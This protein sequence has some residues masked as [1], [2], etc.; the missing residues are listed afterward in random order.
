M[1]A[2]TNGPHLDHVDQSTLNMK[3]VQ[4]G[5]TSTDT[6]STYLSDVSNTADMEPSPTDHLSGNQPILMSQPRIKIPALPKILNTIL[7]PRV[8]CIALYCFCIVVIDLCL[9]F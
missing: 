8:Q 5:S 3:I 6:L 7:E 1:G 4:N 2:M 9:S